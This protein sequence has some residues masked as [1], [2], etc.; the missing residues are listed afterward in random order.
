MQNDIIED[1]YY[2]G[3]KDYMRNNMKKIP[4]ILDYQLEN[5]YPQYANLNVSREK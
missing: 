1:P 3:D 4:K 5:F 2:Q